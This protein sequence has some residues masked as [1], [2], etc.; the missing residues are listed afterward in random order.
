M[1][2][3]IK[4][5][6]LICII[7]LCTATMANAQKLYVS[8][9]GGYGV[10]LFKNT[11]YSDW[12][13]EGTMTIHKTW[14]GTNTITTNDQ[15]QIIDVQ[16]FKGSGSYGKGIQP[17]ATIG[18]MINDYIGAEVNID[19]LFGSEIQEYRTT[20]VDNTVTYNIDLVNPANNNTINNASTSLYDY[21]GKA[22][23]LRIIPGFRLTAT[24]WKVKPYLKAGLVIGVAG[25]Y[26]QNASQSSTDI[27]GVTS[28]LERSYKL[29]G[30]ISLGFA[31]SIGATYEVIKNLGVFA[32][33]GVIAQS[34]C[35]KK[36]VMT[37]SIRD[38]V[39]ELENL[40]VREKEMEF[41]NSASNDVFR[42]G[43][44]TVPAKTTKTSYPF[45]TVGFNVG[46]T[47]AFGLK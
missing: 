11:K 41:G 6:L 30:R 9:G 5:Q 2:N 27:N 8:V 29:T 39:D 12:K 28:T 32:E 15:S 33:A 20:R 17:F 18:Y 35:P 4:T 25:N 46:L 36:S 19:Y 40:T 37:K 34:W 22:S 16:L 44:N 23:M 1:K 31:G 24:D 14:N 10:S 42:P 3:S 45:S 13:S 21:N 26:K 7:V 38:G 43:D 47:Y